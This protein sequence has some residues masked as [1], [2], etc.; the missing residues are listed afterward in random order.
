MDDLTKGDIA[1][2]AVRVAKR[3]V[4]A[5]A[6]GTSQP[7]YAGS[8]SLCARRLAARD[9]LRQLDEVLDVLAELPN[10]TEELERMT[11]RAKR[12]EAIVH[13]MLRE[14]RPPAA[15][16]FDVRKDFAAYVVTTTNAD[17]I[18]ARLRPYGYYPDER[19]D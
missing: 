6:A 16:D 2:A 14:A 1:E 18:W 19:K 4:E 3:A 7:I 9:V 17:E 8:S 11:A 5:I 13:D 15:A 10:P 12:A